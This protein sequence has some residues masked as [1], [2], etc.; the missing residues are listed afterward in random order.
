MI[1]D[2]GEIVIGDVIPSEGI[3]KGKTLLAKRYSVLILLLA[4]KYRHEQFGQRY[5]VHVSRTNMMQPYFIEFE[6]RDSGAARIA[7]EADS[8]ECRIQAVIYILKYPQFEKLLEFLESPPK[9]VYF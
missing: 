5:L 2:L 7:H 9:A 6:A 8:L 3:E 1:H 4:K